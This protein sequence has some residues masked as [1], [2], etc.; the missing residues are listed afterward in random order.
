M[1]WETKTLPDC[2]ILLAT[3][4]MIEADVPPNPGGVLQESDESEYHELWEQAELAKSA[5]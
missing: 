4:T 2:D 1:S 5:L 3:V